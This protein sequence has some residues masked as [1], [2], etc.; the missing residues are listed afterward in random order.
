MITSLDLEGGLSTVDAIIDYSRFI[1]NSLER[2]YHAIGIFVDFSKEFDT[3]NHQI[4]MSKFYS[5]G[6]RGEVNAWFGSYLEDRSQ[7]VRLS[8]S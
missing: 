3:V 7:C 1:F 6:V 4:S 8:N 2:K 5:Y